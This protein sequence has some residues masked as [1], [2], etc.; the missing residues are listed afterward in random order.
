MSGDRH[1]GCVRK[2]ERLVLAREEDHKVT[3][4]LAE[5]QKQLG[6]KVTGLALRLAELE[7]KLAW[8]KRFVRSQSK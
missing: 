7:D 3:A 8:V 6:A 5:T 1:T 4:K 2:I